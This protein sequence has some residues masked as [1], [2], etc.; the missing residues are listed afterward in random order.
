M[1]NYVLFQNFSKWAE[2]EPE[3]NN[4]KRCVVMHSTADKVGLWENINC[5][6]TSSGLCETE[7][8]N[9]KYA[10]ES[11]GFKTLLVIVGKNNALVSSFKKVTDFSN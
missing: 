11:F 8:V 7:A 1:I 5:Y 10:G 6:H 4:G 9:G 2:N 3:W